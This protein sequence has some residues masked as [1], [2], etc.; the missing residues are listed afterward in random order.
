MPLP[1]ALANRPFSPVLFS[2]SADR[3][4]H[5]WHVTRS[6]G[7]VFGRETC[8]TFADSRDCD[9]CE[10]RTW[11]LS[12]WPAGRFH[13][14]CSWNTEPKSWSRL[15]NRHCL[16]RQQQPAS[17]YTWHFKPQPG[18]WNLH[19]PLTPRSWIHTARCN[20]SL[21][22]VNK[23]L[24][25]LLAAIAIWRTWTACCVFAK[26]VCNPK[27]KTFQCCHRI[28]KIRSNKENKIWQRVRL[29]KKFHC[30]ITSPKSPLWFAFAW[31]ETLP[32]YSTTSKQKETRK[33]VPTMLPFLKKL[34][35]MQTIRS[36]KPEK[37]PQILR[38]PKNL[39]PPDARS[40]ASDPTNQ[41]T[42][43]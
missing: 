6:V 39:F 35:T 11:W 23:S 21:S 2:D 7:K 22:I 29:C 36:H 32:C 18:P 41:Q 37:C 8:V 13:R 19:P 15:P 43:D 38:K 33:I 26:Y 14:H 20:Q 24:M 28:I 40:L 5:H 3:G 17:F 1:A 34:P 31:R 25:S 9:W 30:W 16:W 4:R 27:N 42:F 12:T 10:G